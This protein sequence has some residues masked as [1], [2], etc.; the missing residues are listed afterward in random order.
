MRKFTLIMASVAMSVFFA[1]LA[2]ADVPPG[3]QQQG[4]SLFEQM[5]Q[6]GDGIVSESEFQA[7][8]L[9]EQDKTQLFAV[10]DQNGDGIISESEWRAYQESGAVQPR[11]TEEPMAA[12][13]PVKEERRRRNV[14]D[15][16]DEQ[17]YDVNDPR[18]IEPKSRGTRVQPE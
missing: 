2:F 7:Y 8:S 11:A 17:V 18:K 16:W 1:G 3:A 14:G 6:N 9:R 4:Y 12:E 13:E 10:I 15:V 5:D